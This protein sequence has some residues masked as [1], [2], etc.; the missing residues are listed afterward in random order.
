MFHKFAFRKYHGNGCS[1]LVRCVGCKL[2]FAFKALFNLVEHRV[3][4]VCKPT[5][6]VF[7]A[8]DIYS[9]RK[10]VAFAYFLCGMTYFVYR[11][12][13]AH[14]YKIS[15][16]SRNYNKDYCKNRIRF[17]NRTYHISLCVNGRYAPEPNITS[18]RRF[19]LAVKY[20][21]FDAVGCY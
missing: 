3:K 7:S 4:R 8:A 17:K 14:N 18:V 16:H 9:L 10:V 2:F 12:E 13:S 20:A 1:K 15:A 5:D 11:D 6:F 19:C 21:I